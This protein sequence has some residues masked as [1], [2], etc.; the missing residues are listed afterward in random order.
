MVRKFTRDGQHSYLGAPYTE[1]ELRKIE[2]YIYEPPVTVSHPRRESPP[3]VS[4]AGTKRPAKQ[5]QTC[6]LP[7][8]D[9]SS[10]V[11]EEE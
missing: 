3:A 6:A 2:G 7:R 10:P 11:V 4:L 8:G 5:R 1:E 9:R